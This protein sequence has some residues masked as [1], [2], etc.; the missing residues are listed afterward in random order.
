MNVF[1]PI[2]MCTVFSSGLPQKAHSAAVAQA[3]E[4]AFEMISRPRKIR[5]IKSSSTDGI[6]HRLA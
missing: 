6:W 5:N 4:I 2:A 3:R 1:T